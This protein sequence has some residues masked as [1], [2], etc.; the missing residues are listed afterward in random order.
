MNIE[1]T[2]LIIAA[3]LAIVLTVIPLAWLISA[4][5]RSRN[6]RKAMRML[7]KSV[8]A[9]AEERSREMSELLVRMGLE[10]ETQAV[11][12]KEIAV[13]ERALYQQFIN[14]YLRRDWKSASQFHATVDDLLAAFR[15]LRPELPEPDAKPVVTMVSSEE[16]ERERDRSERLQEELKIAHDT[17]GRMLS[18][19]TNMF[20]AGQSG[21]TDE[22][23]AE[24]MSQFEE[25]EEGESVVESAAG[26]GPAEREIE[27]IS[28]TP[29]QTEDDEL[30]LVLLSGDEEDDSTPDPFE[31]SETDDLDPFGD[32]ETEVIRLDENSSMSED[33]RAESEEAK[34][35]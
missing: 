14:L 34:T 11:Q 15:A 22:K 4:L 29:A 18:E 6:D 3:E 7:V 26:D 12:A 35:A 13:L 9:S 31:D 28:E 2:Y 16:L 5:L 8:K 19:Y 24:V 33:G 32:D 25:T 10:G 20:A 30:D 23:K 1:P 27:R 21:A 17:M